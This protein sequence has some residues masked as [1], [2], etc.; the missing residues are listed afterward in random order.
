MYK[1]FVN[2]ILMLALAVPEAMVMQSFIKIGPL[3]SEENRKIQTS[4]MISMMNCSTCLVG[5]VYSH[6]GS[7][8]RF[9]IKLNYLHLI[10]SLQLLLRVDL[11]SKKRNTFLVIF[12]V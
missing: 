12:N 9:I 7:K 11:I 4:G 6:F 3:V 10:N 5:V 8:L 2:T 1:I